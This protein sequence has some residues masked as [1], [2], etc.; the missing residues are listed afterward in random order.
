MYVMNERLDF[1]H[2]PGAGDL[3]LFT[4]VLRIRPAASSP[5]FIVVSVLA[6]CIAM[7]LHAHTYMYNDVSC[8]CE[9]KGTGQFVTLCYRDQ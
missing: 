5:P 6:C 4:A 2:A 7:G 1:R 3:S 8:L 9:I